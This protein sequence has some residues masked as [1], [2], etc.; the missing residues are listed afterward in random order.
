V[1]PVR[2]VLVVDDNCDLADAVAL[3]LEDQGFAT[4]VAYSAEEAWA[5]ARRSLPEIAIVDIK[6]PGVGGVELARQLRKL[7]PLP[8]LLIAFT[9]SMLAAEYASV[10]TEFDAVIRKPAS[11]DD[12]MLA[13]QNGGFQPMS[14]LRRP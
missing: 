8:M 14:A 4:R 11:L 2:R 6:L 5:E 13:I 7:S 3:L 10:S 9:G 1:N 12:I